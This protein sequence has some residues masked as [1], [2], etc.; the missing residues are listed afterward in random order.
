M[1][2]LRILEAGGKTWIV[3]LSI[4]QH[5]TIGRAPDNEVVLDDCRVSRQHAFIK[6]EDGFY[7]L[8]DCSS[9]NHIF[10]NGSDCAEQRL[11]SGD[12]IAIGESTLIFDQ[13]T[14]S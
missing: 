7:V 6:Y 5:C 10:I 13:E 3:Y 2:R 4:D 12:R 1:A 9:A 11:T 14:C 8:V